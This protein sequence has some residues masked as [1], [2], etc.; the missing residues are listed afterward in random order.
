MLFMSLVFTNT[1]YNIAFV[2]I[3]TELAAL[4]KYLIYLASL[5]H[6]YVLW[7]DLKFS[8]FGLVDSLRLKV[9]VSDHDNIHIFD[10]IKYNTHLA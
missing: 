7:L 8:I 5:M 2:R 3:L 10:V 4:F 9:K 1:E 6:K